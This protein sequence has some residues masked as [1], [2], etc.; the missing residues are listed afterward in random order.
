M[1]VFI[2]IVS[3]LLFFLTRSPQHTNTHKNKQTIMYDNPSCSGNGVNSNNNNNQQQPPPPSDPYGMNT[4]PPMYGGSAAHAPAGSLFDNQQLQQQPPQAH[5]PYPTSNPYGAN[6]MPPAPAPAP[7][8]T[9]GVGVG[10]AACRMTRTELQQLLQQS[11]HGSNQMMFNSYF[12]PNSM[13]PLCN[14]CGRT[15]GEHD[16]VVQP[17][18][19]T[20]QPVA[21]TAVAMQPMAP[22]GVML[23]AAGVGVPYTPE[24][25]Q[26]MMPQEKP[27]LP[28]N[29]EEGP[30][31][32]MVYIKFNPVLTIMGAIFFVIGI[33]W[34]VC[35][36]VFLGPVFVIGPVIFVLFGGLF[37]LFPEAHDIEFDKQSRVVNITSR[38]LCCIPCPTRRSATFNELGDV[39]IE[40]TNVRINHV[41]QV[42]IVIP[43]NNSVENGVPLAMVGFHEG[44]QLQLAW[45]L[46][47]MWMKAH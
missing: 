43:V 11:G 45:Q 34:L 27:P 39:T 16:D 14:T 25:L 5:S 23:A 3:Q 32:D 1:K 12:R 10:A 9:A 42:R 41:P 28:P 44:P 7:A 18:A 46:H 19:G 29:L 6:A 21:G 36:A 26:G 20:A 15:I 2:T 38:R 17:V 40:Q 4:A 13:P 22:A 35:A 31:S 33:I 24:M 37:L 47:M 8:P 30:I